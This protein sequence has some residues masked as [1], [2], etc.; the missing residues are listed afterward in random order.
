[1]KRLVVGL[2]FAT[3]ALW[4]APTIDGVITPG[5]GWIHIGSDSL[6]TGGGAGAHLGDFY[7]YGDASAL[8]LAFSTQNTASW[9]VAYGIAL[10]PQ[11][12]FGYVGTPGTDK[13]AWNRYITFDNPPSVNWEFYWYWDGASGAVTAFNE[14]QWTGSGWNYQ[15]QGTYAYTGDATSGLQQL[16]YQVSWTDLGF[17][18][19]QGYVCLTLWIAGTDN[20]S[21]VD[22]IPEDPTVA[23]GG[24]SEWT[25]T[26]DQLGCIE[27]AFPVAVNEAESH[28][29]LQVK[30]VLNGLR[31]I[32]DHPVT[33]TVYRADGRKVL[34]QTVS[35]FLNLSGLEK[36]V[37]LYRIGGSYKNG[38]VMVLR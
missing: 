15:A 7:A 24:G 9:N 11:D 22:V 4:A 5:E 6:A 33:V 17:T 36:G 35:H 23:D 20:S 32:A 26:D 8:Y 30:P 31:V 12:P 10:D 14:C 16:E 2:L 21:A 1:M 27:V 37:Y 29:V 28:P 34:T 19:P 18:S 38:K 3:V 13:D 25:D